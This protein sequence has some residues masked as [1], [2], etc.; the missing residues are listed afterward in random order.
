MNYSNV[1]YYYKLDNKNST[2]DQFDRVEP[3]I[4]HLFRFPHPAL[5]HKSYGA[6][7]CHALMEKNILTCERKNI[8]EVGGGL[9]HFALEF[10]K[11]LQQNKLSPAYT[12]LDLSANL[13]TAQRNLL[14]NNNINFILANAQ[15]LPFLDEAFDGIVIS[16][17]VVAD[18]DAIEYSLADWETS[19]DPMIKY[20][21]EHEE[22]KETKILLNTG[23]INFVEELARVMK[24]GSVAVITEH[25]FEGNGRIAYC[26]SIAAEAAHLEYSINFN[27]LALVAKQH[28]LEVKLVNLIDFLNFNKEVAVANLNDAR[29]L[30]ANDKFWPIAAIPANEIC[31]K[32]KVDINELREIAGLRL[33]KVGAAGFPDDNT[34]PF[35]ISF[36]ALIIQK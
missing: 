8:L 23:A 3:T 11:E 27:H 22:I 32:Y 29:A 36:K 25:G 7:F 16:N 30:N 14:S 26:G 15:Q 10:S 4:S 33:P 28:S 5:N 12:I 21:R 19:N 6:A 17:E 35:N 20:L 31:N 2:S 1:D 24:K 34:L 13:Q 9:G 18:F